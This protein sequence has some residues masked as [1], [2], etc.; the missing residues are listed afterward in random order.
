VLDEEWSVIKSD[1]VWPVIRGILCNSVIQNFIVFGGGVCV[2]LCVGIS[3]PPPFNY[4][5]E[6]S[7]E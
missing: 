4:K 6:A 3:A 7:S 1:S 2:C 5:G